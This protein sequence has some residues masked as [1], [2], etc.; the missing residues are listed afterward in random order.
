MNLTDDEIAQIEELAGLCFIPS[1]ITKILGKDIDEFVNEWR[2]ENSIIRN[3]YDKGA[4]IKEAEIRKSISEL[5]KSGSSSAQQD[6]LKLLRNKNDEI[7]KN[8]A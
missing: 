2:N 8:N 6:Y 5:A 1:D 4:L 7:T 3:H